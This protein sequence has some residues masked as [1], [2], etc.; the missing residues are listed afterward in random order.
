M[1]NPES[2]TT[3]ETKRLA[4]RIRGL[5]E[6]KNFSDAEALGEE[7]TRRQPSDT[8]LLAEHAETAVR[9]KSWGSAV[10]RFT[11][12]IRLETDD[13]SR[14]RAVLSLAAVYVM[15][16]QS[17][18]AVSVVK[19]GIAEGGGSLSLLRA[20]AELRLLHPDTRFD[21]GRWQA[22]AVS[23]ALAAA[24]VPARISAVAACAAGL[25]LAGKD[26]EAEQ[27]LEEH[28]LTSDP[29]RRALLNEGYAKLVVFD[30][31]RTRVEFHTKL[32]DPATGA[33][34]VS[35]Q[36]AITFDVMEQTWD[37]ESFA[38]RPLSRE[39]I[40][41][42]AVRK[43]TKE[44]FHQ[45]FRREDF[46]SFATPIAAGYSDVVALGQSLGAYSALYYASWLPGCR[47][48]ATA[49]RNPLHPRYAGKRHASYKLFTHE[50]EMP[51]NAWVRPTIVYDPKNSEDGRYVE[52]S[53]AVSFP[54]S[55]RLAYPY[56]GHSITRYLRD[57]G[58]LKN[59]TLDFC[60]GKPF[61]EFDRTKRGGSSEYF[62][63]LARVNLRAGRAKRARALALR[64]LE[65]GQET[66]RTRELLLKIDALCAR[67]GMAAVKNPNPA[68]E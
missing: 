66:D 28:L 52:K 27:L 40:D 45:E 25:R 44:D 22:L 14:D 3:W 18:E 54:G 64:A 42:L 36:L 56:C 39:R 15:L 6:G 21:A 34:V 7:A 2:S 37:K 24:D 29:V 16:G 10:K 38:Y 19:S 41:I 60:Q 43:R 58:G 4:D 30:N 8:A 53:L 59:A 33:L 32:I 26:G 1:K 67:G 5:R 61:P 50:Y 13:P 12:L 23:P 9:T 49:P 57:V 35:D 48:L 31:G 68:G 11:R 65:L 46:L 62:R 55:L 51:A 63:N 17:A 47:I 20:E